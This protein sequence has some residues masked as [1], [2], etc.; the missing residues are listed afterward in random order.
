MGPSVSGFAFEFTIAGDDEGKTDAKENTI[1]RGSESRRWESNTCA[2][3][4]VMND[5]FT[6]PIA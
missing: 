1:G 3:G 4:A 2:P 6:G 5:Q